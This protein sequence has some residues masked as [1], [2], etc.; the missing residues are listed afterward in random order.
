MCGRLLRASSVC[1]RVCVCV[2]ECV[3]VW[4]PPRA[5]VHLFVCAC[6]CVR[7]RV[8]SWACAFL[9]RLV[10]RGPDV[11]V[12]RIWSLWGVT[13]GRLTLVP[14]TSDEVTSLS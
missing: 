9:G 7:V 6:A 4:V 3:C 8:P 11:Q 13:C 10:H 1:T 5:C 14:L 2:F 12:G